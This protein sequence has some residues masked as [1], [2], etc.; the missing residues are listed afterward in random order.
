MN[1]LNTLFCWAFLSL[2]L[3]VNASAV[4]SPLMGVVR[5]TS[6]T[7]TDLRISVGP[8][9][10]GDSRSTTPLP[11]DEVTIGPVSSI[12]A[13][14]GAPVHHSAAV[15]VLDTPR[16]A[17]ANGNTQA[18][19]HQPVPSRGSRSSRRHSG[20]GHG[21]P[22]HDRTRS[23]FVF[24]DQD[25]A[26]MK[27]YEIPAEQEGVHMHSIGEDGDKDEADETVQ[28]KKTVSCFSRWCCCAGSKKNKKTTLPA[29]TPNAPQSARNID[30]NS[31]AG[32]GDYL[33]MGCASVASTPASAKRH[34]WNAV[35]EGAL[36]QNNDS[37]ANG[38]KSG[39]VGAGKNASANGNHDSI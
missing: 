36:A 21:V 27:L 37:R 39:A 25:A 6:S 11:S 16:A 13:A 7:Y 32:S 19:S 12:A 31:A 8:N 23:S 22:G 3:N 20:K 18:T 14:E 4:D 2:S 5:R 34:T 30:R 28:Q 10:R 38:T 17:E 9:S 24:S 1:N 35:A 15:S 26:R 33:S 29:N